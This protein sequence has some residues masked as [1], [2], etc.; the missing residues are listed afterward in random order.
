MSEIDNSIY[1]YI[2]CDDE[3]CNMGHAEYRCPKCGT[4]NENYDDLWFD[5]EKPGITRIVVDS[6]SNCS[7]GLGARY[8]EK[9]IIIET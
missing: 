4:M 8:R 3:F 7:C 6:C 2:H 1:F 5:R 9:W